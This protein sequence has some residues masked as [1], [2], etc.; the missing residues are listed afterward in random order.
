MVSCMDVAWYVRSCPLVVLDF[1]MLVSLVLVAI[2][3]ASG[4][5]HSLRMLIHNF[6]VVSHFL[7]S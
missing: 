6:F 5:D 3:S 7:S 2:I 4:V 1:V